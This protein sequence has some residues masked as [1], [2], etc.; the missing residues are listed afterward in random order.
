MKWT[1]AHLGGG[2]PSRDL[3][4]TLGRRQPEH[5][6]LGDELLQELVVIREREVP[7][8]RL[9]RR[10]TAADPAD[11]DPAAIDRDLIGVLKM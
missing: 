4:T 1:V 7:G 3:G 5:L 9:R 8:Q 2:G 11:E 6:E 10:G